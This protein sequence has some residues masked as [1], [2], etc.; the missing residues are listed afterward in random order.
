MEDELKQAIPK[1]NVERASVYS[2]SDSDDDGLIIVEDDDE[3][4]KGAGNPSKDAGDKD[5]GEEVATVTSGK[6]TAAMKNNDKEI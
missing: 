6:N 1:L 3:E 4:H 5:G 2:S